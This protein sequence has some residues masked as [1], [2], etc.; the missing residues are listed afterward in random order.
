MVIRLIA[1]A[2]LF[3]SFYGYINLFSKKIKP[4][5]AIGVT[6]ALIGSV[7]FLAGIFNIFVVC[8]YTLWAAGIILAGYSFFKKEYIINTITFGTIFFVGMSIVLL[9]IIKG[10]VFIHYDNFS[11]WGLI[12]KFLLNYDRLPVETDINIKFISYP[13]GSASFIYYFCK[14]CRGNSEWLQMYAQAVL[15]LGMMVSLFAFCKTKTE[16]IVVAFA[17]VMLIAGNIG[18]QELLVDTLLPAT[19]TALI[20]LCIFYKKELYSKII[21]SVPFM[22]FIVSIKN[23]GLLFAVFAIIY[24]FIYIIADNRTFKSFFKWI[25]CS[26]V[27][28]SSLVFWKIHIKTEFTS[29]NTAKHS[30]SMENFEKVFSD[31]SVQDIKDITALFMDKFLSFENPAIYSVVFVVILLIVALVFTNEKNTDVIETAIMAVLSYVV[32]QIGLLGMYFFTM[33]LNEALNLA[34]YNRYHKTILIYF[35]AI[36]CICAI[37]LYSDFSKK[38]IVTI[39]VLFTSIINVWITVKPDMETYKPQENMNYTDRGLYSSIIE[40]YEIPS[41]KSYAVV[42]SDDRLKG[43]YLWYL[44]TYLLD[45]SKKMKDLKMHDIIEYSDVIK[46]YEYLII[47]DVTEEINI[48]AEE[49]FGLDYPRVIHIP[50]YFA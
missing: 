4:E 38:Q 24:L 26:A 33:P 45:P 35:A 19:A 17:T 10:S 3:I 43:D 5:M 48:W 1:I 11:H 46:E 2:V 8:A 18:F 30:M 44:G 20:S 34:A 37:K 31:K 6:F 13:T 16:N 9:F 25:I 49:M 28:L 39:L 32:Y 47:F 15:I 29:G 23:S 42:M 36:L 40:Q 22:F 41:G 21:Y 50:E 27:S 7:M 12:S 14:M